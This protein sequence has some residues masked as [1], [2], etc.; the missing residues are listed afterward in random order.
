MTYS[1]TF[2]EWYDFL[3]QFLEKP[4][5][6]HRRARLL[7]GLRGR[8]LEVGAGTG[9]NFEHYHPEA[10]VVGIEPSPWMIRQAIERK[11][12][13][14]TGAGITLH[15][16]GCG[17][18]QLH[19]IVEE[20]SLDYVVCTLVLCTIPDPEAALRDF[21]KWLKPGGQLIVLEHIRSHHR[22]I[23]RLQDI[24]R[25]AWARIADGCQL[26]RPTDKLIAGAGFVPLRQEWFRVGLPFYE[27]VWG[28]GL[29]TEKQGMIP[30]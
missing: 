12:Q 19:D 11:N 28:K 27:G 8:I 1:R 6:R 15:Q 30:V 22:H 7:A 2:G 16:T 23:G 10:E 26:N 20:S 21:S 9:I 29:K 13:S 4:W 14:A 5:L 24:L 18:P 17:D 3:M 25:P